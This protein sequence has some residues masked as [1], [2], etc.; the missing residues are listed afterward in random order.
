M[1]SFLGTL[2]VRR[3]DEPGLSGVVGERPRKVLPNQ[4][5]VVTVGVLF[6]LFP[7]LSYLPEGTVRHSQLY[8]GVGAAATVASVLLRDNPR[9]TV[10]S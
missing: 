3:H 7:F 5:Y 6:F 2:S 1:E 9:R 4:I 10:T 8:R